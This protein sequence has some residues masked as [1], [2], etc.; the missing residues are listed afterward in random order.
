MKKNLLSMRQFQKNQ[1]KMKMFC[2]LIVVIQEV[3]VLKLC[4]RMKKVRG[5]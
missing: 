1:M 4:I 5:W 3:V 2:I